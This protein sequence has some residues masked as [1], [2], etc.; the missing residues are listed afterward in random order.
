MRIEK[1]VSVSTATASTGPGRSTRGSRLASIAVASALFM[2]FLD[3]TALSTALPTLSVAFGTDPVH[4]KLALT[5]YILALAVLAPASGWIADRYG[6]RRVF[7]VAMGVFLTAS[8]LCGFSRSLGQLVL[9]RTLQGLGGALMTPVGRL[10]IVNSAPRERLV[11]AMSWFTMPALVGPLLGPPLAGFILGVADW[12]WIFFINVPVGLL[13]MW[14]VARFVPVLK[15]PDP[16]PFDKKGFALAVVAIT[17]LMGAAETAGIGLVPWPAQLGIALVAVGALAAYV[18]HALR[19][20]RPVLNLRLLQVPTFRASMLGGALVRM[21][22]GATPFLLPLLFQ[23]GL[24]WGPLEAGLVTIGTSMGAFA[25]K[26]VAPVL[27]R[28]VG[29]RK[30]LIIS[31]LLTAALTAV[32]AFFRMST[33]IPFI[34]GTL[35][36]SGFM[37]SLQFT[38]TNTVAYADLPREAVSSASTLAVVTQQMALS[39]GISFGGLMLHVARGGGD[40]R[41]TPDRFLLPFLAI[42]LVSSL[43]GPL[44]RRLPPD[45]GAQIGGR[46]T[47]RG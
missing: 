28:R 39:V 45:A 15:Q 14:A 4:L 34:I 44:F 24:G 38:A 1:D 31:N 18:R 13:G 27:I 26:P 10:I 17:T 47:A 5:S 29:F 3:S 43:A 8:V 37:R 21:G 2:E 46:A 20:P 35:I 36:C 33:P 32:P 16:G 41:L 40:V 23:V 42:G 9:F 25:C 30:T 12:P 11:S 7:M 6:P 19:T 22:L